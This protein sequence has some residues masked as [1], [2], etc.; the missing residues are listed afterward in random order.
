[1][2]KVGLIT[3]GSDSPGV[4]AAIR[5]FGKAVANKHNMEVLGF[6]DGYLGLVEDRKV[7]LLE[8]TMLSG[9]LTEG[10][11]ILGTSRHVPECMPSPEGATDRTQEAIDTYR[12]NELDALV[13][14][15]DNKSQQAAYHLS[16]AGLN[17]I[18]LP[19]SCENDVPLTDKSIGFDTAREIATQAIDR[20]HTN[21]NATH[22]IMLVELLG[23]YSGW[24]T[25]GAGLAAGADVILI[26]EIPY[27]F[28]VVIEAIQRRKK[29]GR[30][31]SLVAVAE[32][33]K[34]KELVDFMAL[35]ASRRAAN[36]EEQ[37]RAYEEIEKNYSAQ[38]LLLARRLGEAADI[39][40]HITILGS[41][42][43]G[44]T[45]TAADRLLAT[46][47]A[48]WSVKMVVEGIFG[49]MAC[50]I[51]GSVTNVPLSEV[52]GKVKQIPLDHDWIRGSYRVG[53]CL[54]VAEESL[55]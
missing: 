9:I 4:N 38:T 19:K 24:L 23:N 46:Q 54:G 35:A 30:N 1:M 39:E 41:L 50:R 21:A 5:G 37:V 15:G 12:R 13:I 43:R 11:T 40:T 14:I 10:G 22:R 16:Q 27:E 55:E 17:I 8:G 33:A 53:A 29:A 49:Q 7:N 52:A 6:R 32:K 42:V 51:D 20:L 18:T 3:A 47:L 25:M 48:E 36:A 31:F 26:P 45:P 2:M 34:S 44:G 28:D